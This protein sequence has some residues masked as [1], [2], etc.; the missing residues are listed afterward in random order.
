[1]NELMFHCGGPLNR[2]TVISIVTTV[3]GLPG[4]RE[5]PHGREGA[6]DVD[7]GPLLAGVSL[8]AT[9]VT[10]GAA[11]AWG[12]AR[13]AEPLR[14]GGEFLGMG[15]EIGGEKRYALGVL[16][17][18]DAFLAWSKTAPLWPDAQPVDAFDDV[19]PWWWRLPLHAVTLLLLALIW[20]PLRRS[21]S[22]PPGG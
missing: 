6:G 7:S 8:S 22:R 3:A 2:R 19:A 12:D 18:G 11:R 15:I 5:Y 9:T 21:S 14:F 20:L 16:P 13:L 4:V 1:M 17:V 10:L